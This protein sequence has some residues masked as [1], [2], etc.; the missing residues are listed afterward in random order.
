MS[1]HET[2]HAEGDCIGSHRHGLAYAALVLD[3]AYEE[4]GPDGAWRLEAGDLIVHPPFHVHLNRFKRGSARVLNLTLTH[5]V[6]SALSAHRYVVLRLRDPQRIARGARRDVMATLSEAME[7]GAPRS[8]DAGADWLDKLAAAL[9]AAPRTE[10]GPLARSLGVTPTHA[11]RAFHRRYGQTPATFRKEQ[12]L[13]LALQE[14]ARDA[15]SLADIAAIAGF[16]DQPHMTRA[17][18]EATGA[19]PSQLRAALN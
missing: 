19:T 4:A 13:R 12:R 11:A 8:S 2:R 7:E 5:A 18:V 1:V 17:L 10:I 16:S 9:S 14:L 3:G 15:S 6:A